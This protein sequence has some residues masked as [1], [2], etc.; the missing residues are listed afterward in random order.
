MIRKFERYL[1]LMLLVVILST[2][3]SCGVSDPEKRVYDETKFF[4]ID[5]STILNGLT[6]DRSEVFTPKDTSPYA[7][8]QDLNDP[9]QWDEAA[10]FRVAQALHELVWDESLD[11]WQ[12]KVLDF[13]FDCS[14]LGNGPQSAGFTYIKIDQIR[15]KESRFL[16]QLIIEPRRNSVIAYKEEMYPHQELFRTIDLDELKISLQE[17]IE[18]VEDNGGSDIREEVANQCTI[19]VILNPGLV[20][21]YV[22]R[23]SYQSESDSELLSVYYIDPL[24]GDLTIK[25]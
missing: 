19:T 3:S 8:N 21:D 14:Y 15:E 18:K 23:V 1:K 13:D 11:D 25:K 9:V 10:Y 16:S 5:P 22:W 12:L 17:V 2:T 7:N 24:T 6:Q 20:R 4:S